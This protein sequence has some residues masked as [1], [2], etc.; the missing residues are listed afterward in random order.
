MF[1]KCSSPDYGEE[2]LHG[3]I[4]SPILSQGKISNQART[5]IN[6]SNWVLFGGADP[7]REGVV[8]GD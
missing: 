2:P 4:R 6:T 8:L 5:D 7:R 3:V 1:N